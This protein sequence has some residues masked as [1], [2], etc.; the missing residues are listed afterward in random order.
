MNKY[1][2][3]F[4]LSYLLTAILAISLCA[5]IYELVINSNLPDWL[6]FMILR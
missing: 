6:K 4:M 3:I 1:Q 5:T 2:W